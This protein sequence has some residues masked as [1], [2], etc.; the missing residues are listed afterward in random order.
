MSKS[1][2]N[3][4]LTAKKQVSQGVDPVPTPAANAMLV[5]ALAPK[6]I[7][8]EFL[9]RNNIRA[10]QGT[11][12]KLSAGVHRVFEFEHE[13][14]GSGVVATAPKWGV[15]LHGCKFQETVTPATNVVYSL[16]SSLVPRLTLYGYL[17]GILWKMVDAWGTVSFELNAKSIPVAKYRYLGEYQTAVDAAFPTTEDYSGFIKPVT[18]GKL[19]TPS[20]TFHGHA[21]VMSQLSIDVGNELSYRDLVQGGGPHSPDRTVTGSTT[22]ELPSIADKNWGEVVRLNSEGALQLV[23]GNVAGNI[24]QFDVP[25]AQITGEPTINDDNKVAM[26][27]LPFSGNLNAK[28][29]E[30][31]ITLT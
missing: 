7:S 5:R 18:V 10:S 22:F 2:K 27:Q 15:L 21:G 17:D 14:A 13:L 23:H 29:D 25:N 20:F 26:I 11:T 9:E 31:S 24:I 6:P 3:M 12:G 28:N 16:I 1:M 30:L 19:N 8:V 4:I